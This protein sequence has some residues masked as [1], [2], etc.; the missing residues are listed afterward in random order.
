MRSSDEVLAILFRSSATERRERKPSSS[1]A[2]KICQAICAVS[3]DSS[4][5]GQL[6]VVIIGQNDDLSCAQFPVESGALETIAGTVVRRAMRV[7]LAYR[8]CGGA[9]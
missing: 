1:N 4:G 8:F 3:N 6:G 9:T 5:S 2:G 7:R